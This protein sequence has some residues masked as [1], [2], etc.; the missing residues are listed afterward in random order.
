MFELWIKSTWVDGEKTVSAQSS[1][2][3]SEIEKDIAD[4]SNEAKIQEQQ[5]KETSLE[6]DVESSDKA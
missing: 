3:S 1:D 4:N 6:E 2:S 5:T